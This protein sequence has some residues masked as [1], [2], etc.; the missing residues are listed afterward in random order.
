MSFTDQYEYPVANFEA[1][2]RA[3]IVLR[4][5]QIE[6]VNAIFNYFLTKHGN[7]LIIMPTGTGK[8]LVIAGIIMRAL[9][10]YTGGGR[11]M[12]L[13][14]VKKLIDQNYKKLLELWPQAPAGIYS[15]GLK[16]RDTQQDIIFGG[17]MSVK[18]CVEKF[19]HID[20]LI[21]DEAHLISPN[22]TTTY[23]FIIDELKKKNPNLVVIG[24]TATG[25]RMGLG[26]LTEPSPTDGSQ[27]FTD[28]AID[29]S[30]PECWGRFIYE[31]Y[32]VPPIPKHMKVEIDISSVG[33]AN[34]D[35][36]QGKLEA[37][38]NKREITV[39]CVQEMLAYAHQRQ[40]WLAFCAGLKNAHDVAECLREHGIIAWDMST[41]NTDQENIR[42]YTAWERGEIRCL[43][44]YNMLTT[45]VDHPAIDLLAIMR[46]TMST[47][48]WVQ[49]VG[50]GTRPSP[51]TGKRDCV[52]LDF[53]RNAE[54]LGP[55]DRPFIP[56][57][58]GTGG[59][60]IPVKI[61]E[62]NDCNTYNHI[63]A[64]EC[65]CCG[66]P[67]PIQSKIEDT[68]STTPLLASQ[69]PIIELFN[70]QRCGYHLNISRV[71]GK[72]SLRVDYF[73]DT[74]RMF[75]ELFHFGKD[76]KDFTRH[77]ANTFWRQR[78]NEYQVP[79]PMSNQQALEI[80]RTFP[81]RTPSRVR[82]WMNKGK[83]PEVTSTLF[84]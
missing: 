74:G 12:C 82:V 43:T 51:S 16:R 18:H 38:V 21:V 57:K 4:D 17:V 8:S 27:L 22:D 14:H 35:Y 31:K 33:M 28:V 2:L 44:N 79:I 64:R 49:M 25:Y 52:V 34:G 19:G 50:R 75:S 46:H 81:A 47:S 9:R 5:Y 58:K 78:Y 32:L 42:R 60:E 71:S 1:R 30:S 66:A 37:A 83:Y 23:R 53:A 36:A 40:V 45:G 3:P 56:R 80:L 70:V 63:S 73:C 84:E 61:C 72:E 59:G 54:R 68:A 48:L 15:A 55:I 26:L 29:L 6:A 39:Q 67:F 76:E 20:V 41:R 65:I 13:T 10:E 62:V 77:R 7:P 24:L 11:F 69:A